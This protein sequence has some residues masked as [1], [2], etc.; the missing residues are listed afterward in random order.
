MKDTESFWSKLKKT[1]RI[2]GFD[3]QNFQEKWGVNITLI[4]L[5]SFILLFV[6]LIGVSTVLLIS[7]TPLGT[8]LPNNQN[9]HGRN[10]IEQQYIHI[11]AL[12]KSV[13][14]QNS[15]IK[16]LQEVILGKKSID[17]TLI[18]EPKSIKTESTT[19]DTSRTEN[20]LLLAQEIEAQNGNIS[21][22]K[23]IESS[24]LF[25]LAD[26]VK[27]I[28]SQKFDANYHPGIDIVSKVNTPI[29]A[30]ANGLVIFSGYSEEDGNFIVLSHPNGFS[31]YYKHANKVLKKTGDKIQKGDPIALIG[32]TGEHSSGPH[33]HFELW[34]NNIA[35]DP[36]K[37]LSFG[38]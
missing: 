21:E 32:N 27:G 35:L 31:S 13:D 23:N 37:Y 2:A 18:L 11:N 28:I 10:Q 20:E 12:K 26:P 30:C 4:Q 19:I 29:K 36:L 22:V 6:L 5:I 17:S 25:I 38:N 9:F 24:R 1:T 15:Y 14:A 33:L 16:N 34:E 8:L 7:Y 3:P